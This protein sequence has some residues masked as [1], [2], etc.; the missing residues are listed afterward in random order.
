MTIMDFT[1]FPAGSL[2][3]GRRVEICP[4]CNRN[5]QATH[6]GDGSSIYIHMARPIG[7]GLFAGIVSIDHCTVG[8][9]WPSNAKTS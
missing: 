6:Y 1:T 8:E 4:R 9:E 2:A 3:E 5:G 7:S